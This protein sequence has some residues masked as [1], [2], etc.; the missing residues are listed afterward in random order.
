MRPL[1]V[2]A[3]TTSLLQPLDVY[4]F[5][6]FKELLR[7]RFHDRYA[8]RSEGVDMQWF[9]RVLYEVIDE[10]IVARPWPHIFPNVGLSDG[11]LHV[12]R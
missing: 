12:S 1:F 5:R 10:V 11:Q 3:K 7:R 6:V 2:P 4:V 8:V 9:L